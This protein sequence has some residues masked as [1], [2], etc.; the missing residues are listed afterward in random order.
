[1][2]TMMTEKK[3]KKDN[4]DDDDDNGDV[5][6]FFLLSGSKV[7]HQLQHDRST[8]THCRLSR[9]GNSG[10]TGHTIKTRVPETIRKAPL[11]KAQTALAEHKVR[12]VE[13]RYL[14]RYRNYVKS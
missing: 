1:M 6:G 3:E 13:R 9:S 11:A 4:V 12:Y 2:L 10:K 5:V 8:C 14:S 7:S